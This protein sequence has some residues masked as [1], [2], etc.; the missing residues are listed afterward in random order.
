MMFMTEDAI[1]ET[2]ATQTGTLRETLPSQSIA[3]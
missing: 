3:I 1:A 2:G